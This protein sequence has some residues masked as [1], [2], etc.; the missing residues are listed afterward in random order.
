ML[1]SFSCS[2]ARPDD[3]CSPP[4][5]FT[6]PQ[7]LHVPEILLAV[8]SSFNANSFEAV[9]DLAHF[10]L[11]CISWTGPAQSILYRRITGVW[12]FSQV[13][14]QLQSFAAHP[15]L[16]PLVREVTV[17]GHDENLFRQEIMDHV[18]SPEA[19]VVIE[20]E[21]EAK[22]RCTDY[23]SDVF[24]TREIHVEVGERMITELI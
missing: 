7:A 2:P 11:V 10:S 9:L 15:K 17:S 4:A 23:D 8:F 5:R 12:R 16:C 3:V 18:M 13:G 20:Q 22:L 14:K 19:D 1:S 21:V 6:G 24:D